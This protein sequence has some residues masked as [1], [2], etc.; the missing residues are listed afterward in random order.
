MGAPVAA[1]CGLPERVEP[2]RGSGWLHWAATLAG[3]RPLVLGPLN[4]DFLAPAFLFAATNTRP[5]AVPV[6][7]SRDLEESTVLL[8]SG[9]PLPFAKPVIPSLAFVLLS[10]FR[11]NR[12]P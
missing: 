11:E 8:E 4:L 9:D 12:R 1:L 6:C 10:I 5:V 7:C 3:W 2:A